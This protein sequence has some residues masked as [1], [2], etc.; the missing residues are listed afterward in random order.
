VKGTITDSTFLLLYFAMFTGLAAGFA[1]NANLKDLCADSGGNA[2]VK[3][4][5]L[6]AMANALGRILWGMIFD[7]FTAKSVIQAN[8]I[9]QALLLMFAPLL[10][11]S[12]TGLLGFAIIA[13]FNYGGVLVVYAGAVAGI[14]GA[15]K[16]ASVYGLLFSAN[17]PGAVAPL[18]AAFSYDRTGSFLPALMA[19]AGLLLVSVIL[20]QWR[21]CALAGIRS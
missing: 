16:V 20:L 2:G 17:I 8:L 19:I 6:F 12:T 15:Q 10:L 21:K 18:A 7:R 11:I 14:W 9:S 5:A 3:A 13:G 1:V 4:V